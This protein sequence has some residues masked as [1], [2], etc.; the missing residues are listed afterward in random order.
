[1]FYMV[2]INFTEFCSIL[3]FRQH[4]NLLHYFGVSDMYFICRMKPL[5][6]DI[7]RCTDEVLK[8][9][10]KGVEEM[11]ASKDSTLLTKLVSKFLLE[12]Q[13]KGFEHVDISE[14]EVKANYPQYSGTTS[15]KLFMRTTQIK[16]NL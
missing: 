14:H 8:C 9:E 6:Y 5:T 13:S 2:C 10:W 15:Y 7:N 3:A 16:E 12:S 11:A 1:M 4:H